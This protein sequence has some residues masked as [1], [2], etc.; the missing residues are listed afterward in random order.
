MQLKAIVLKPRL[1]RMR[2]IPHGPVR[3][4]DDRRSAEN[5]CEGLREELIADRC[6]I[7]PRGVVQPLIVIA[8][9]GEVGNGEIVENVTNG[10]VLRG[11]GG[12]GQITGD[13]HR[14]QIVRCIAS[15]L[16]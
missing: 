1:T 5:G 13:E 8:N 11:Q 6:H 3:I 12:I 7:F 14:L 10:L 9:D 15:E 4:V 2:G 16:I